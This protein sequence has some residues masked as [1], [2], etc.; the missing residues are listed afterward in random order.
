MAVQ[1]HPEQIVPETT[2]QE[3]KDGCGGRIASSQLWKEIYGRRIATQLGLGK[4][5]R[6]ISKNQSKSGWIFVILAVYCLPIWHKVMSS[7]PKNAEKINSI[8]R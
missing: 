6:P 8:Q 2:S 3:N 1:G 7:N 5:Q 4:K